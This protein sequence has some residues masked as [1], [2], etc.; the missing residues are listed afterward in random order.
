MLSSHGAN[1]GGMRVLGPNTVPAAITAWPKKGTGA[2][3]GPGPFAR[4]GARIRNKATH[5]VLLP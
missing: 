5:G 2:I 4:P 1:T 3:K